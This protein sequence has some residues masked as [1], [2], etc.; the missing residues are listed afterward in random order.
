[1][2]TESESLEI[3]KSA[4]HFDGLNIANW[5]RE[6][7]TAWHEGGITGVSCTCGI[8]ENFRD[9]IANVVQ[10]KKWFEEH[11]DLIMQAHNVRDIRRAKEQGKT[12]VL[13]SWQNTA[14]IE[15]NLDYLRV[16]RDLGVR[17]MQL[18][19]NTANYSGSGYTELRDG[20]LTGFGRQVVD[21]MAK[22]GVVCDLSHVGPITTRDVIEYS[23][24]E[25]PPCFSHV[26]PG[27]L[28]EHPRN[29]SDELIRLLG[30]KGGFIGLSQFGPHMEKGNDSTIDDYVAALDYVISLVGEDL[31]GVGSDASEGH[32]RPSEFMA[33]CNLDKGYA[34][35]LT[36]WGSQK[37]VK[38]LGALKDRA[39]L[40]KAMG[41][42]GWGETKMKKVLGE[43][44][45]NYLEKIFGE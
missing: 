19:Y 38:P 10:W 17:K 12:A 35:K 41:R 40:A 3:Y 16:F 31:V 43:N 32:A 34:R 45:L 6:I 29:K 25:K 4:I 26:L 9:A 36:P 37:V 5:S 21:E 15:D 23:S 39:E 13:L 1:M 22:L 7:F 44:W 30:E 11:S 14:G 42:A 27:G 18:T 24:V 20:G 33:W 8:W 28:K 2:P